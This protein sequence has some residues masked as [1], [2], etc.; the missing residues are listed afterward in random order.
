[1]F[2]WKLRPLGLFSL[3]EGKLKRMRRCREEK[4]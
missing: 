2:E 1:M 4:V 3:E